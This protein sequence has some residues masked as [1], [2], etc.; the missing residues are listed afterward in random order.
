MVFI[1]TTLLWVNN[2]VQD[3]SSNLSSDPSFSS[4]VVPTQGVTSWNPVEDEGK[5]S[6]QNQFKSRNTNIPT[7]GEKEGQGPETRASARN[8][9]KEE[10]HSRTETGSM[11]TGIM[12][13]G[14]FHVT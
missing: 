12:S 6:P 11:Y 1:S 8:K 3:I 9:E 4:L 2:R 7:S 13:L 5:V 14:R 10:S